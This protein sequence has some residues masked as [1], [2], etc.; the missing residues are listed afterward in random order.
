MHAGHI[1]V[2]AVGVTG[3]GR[4]W[5]TEATA[6]VLGAYATPSPFDSYG[7]RVVECSD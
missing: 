5:S 4:I 3:C 6:S 1:P 7:Q 2:A